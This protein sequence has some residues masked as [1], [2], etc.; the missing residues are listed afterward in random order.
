MNM[1]PNTSYRSYRSYSTSVWCAILN[2]HFERCIMLDIKRIREKTEEVRA[3]LMRRGADVSLVDNVLAFDEQRRKFIAATEEKKQKRN[4]VSK[5]VGEL[6]KKGEDTAA[7]QA[8]MRAL[9]EEI[10]E[11]DKQVAD[12][13]AQQQQA[14]LRIPNIPAPLVRM[15]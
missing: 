12:V 4:T 11:L 15:P 10:A 13:E 9:G 7:I 2:H 6:K 5:Q 8:E 3:G 14:V 1:C